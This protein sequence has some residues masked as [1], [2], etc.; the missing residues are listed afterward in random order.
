MT[1][2]NRL[3][4]LLLSISLI[5]LAAYFALD[6]SFRRIVRNR[7]QNALRSAL[8]ERARDELIQT[9]GNYDEKL[10][11]SAQAVRYRRCNTACRQLRQLK[12]ACCLPSLVHRKVS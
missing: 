4:I 10:K 3:L 7:I 1:I 9:I 5:P 8:E 6:I 12:K 2:R 11:I